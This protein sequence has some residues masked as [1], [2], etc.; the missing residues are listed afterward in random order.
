MGWIN[1]AGR[2]VD[3]YGPWALIPIMALV[4]AVLLSRILK[5][6]HDVQ[7]RLIDANLAEAMQLEGV[8]RDVRALTVAIAGPARR[9]RKE[10]K[11]K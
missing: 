3:R 9:Q 7:I 8:R 2:L 6:H 10:R 11:G 5:A 1:E 4:F